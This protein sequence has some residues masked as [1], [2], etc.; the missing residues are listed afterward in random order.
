MAS[1]KIISV[2]YNFCWRVLVLSFQ[3]LDIHIY[4]CNAL[5]QNIQRQLKLQ[6][7]SQIK[8]KK[9]YKKRFLIN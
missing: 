4:T 3:S 2:T 6:I 9:I 5:T 1:D 7:K 8:V